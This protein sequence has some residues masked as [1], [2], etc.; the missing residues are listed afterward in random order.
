[1]KDTKKRV[2]AEFNFGK[3][4][5]FDTLIKEYPDLNL[6]YNKLRRWVWTPDL[7]MMVLL[8]WFE[9]DDD[10][11]DE[12]LPNYGLTD[13]DLNV[14]FPNYGLT[15]VAVLTWVKKKKHVTF[16]LEKANAA[17]KAANAALKA[18]NAS[19]KKEIALLKK[20]SGEQ[21]NKS[22]L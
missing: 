20:G 10:L 3:G 7:K 21:K 22:G 19:L 6:T 14:R 12:D 13:E 11:T 17:L 18:V 16:K 1:M 2:I 15:R 8:D 4:K 9:V 5:D